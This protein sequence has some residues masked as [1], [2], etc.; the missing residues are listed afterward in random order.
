VKEG[1]H[2]TNNDQEKGL[3]LNLCEQIN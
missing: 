1:S 2:A 3:K